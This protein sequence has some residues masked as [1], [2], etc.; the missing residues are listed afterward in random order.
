[1]FRQILFITSYTSAIGTSDI[2]TAHS[3]VNELPDLQQIMD[4]QQAVADATATIMQSVRTL[5]TDMA[6]KADKEKQQEKKAAA[7]VVNAAKKEVA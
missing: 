6:N 1:M 5:S 4:K 3:K 7:L 2:N